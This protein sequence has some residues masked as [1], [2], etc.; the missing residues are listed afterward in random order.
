MLPSRHV[1]LATAVAVPL[2]P[3]LGW[4]AATF[5]VASILVDAD[6]YLW[7]VR[8]YRRWNP[9]AAYRRFVREHPARGEVRP[10]FHHWTFAAV[11]AAGSAALPA[12]LP[13]LGG[14]LFHLVLD[15][16]GRFLVKLRDGFRCRG[17]GVHTWRIEVHKAALTAPGRPTYSRRRVALCRE[18]HVLAHQPGDPR[19]RPG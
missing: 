8:R 16:R 5:W 11:L 6:Y 12:L 13:V 18:C 1:A 7:Y 15:D 3:V 17:C 4:Q 10:I 2:A 19:P 14:V 9:V